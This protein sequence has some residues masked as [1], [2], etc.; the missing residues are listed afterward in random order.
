MI[1]KHVITIFY[2]VAFFKRYT[3]FPE[4]TK[5]H[6]QQH[7][8]KIQLCLTSNSS[9]DSSSLNLAK[10]TLI[11]NS[12]IDITFLFTATNE[13]WEIRNYNRKLFLRS[14][15]KKNKNAASILNC[16]FLKEI[17]TLAH[18]TKYLYVVN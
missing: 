10:N 13:L 2:T 17:F 4:H 8:K 1:L 16:Y 12:T 9:L 3:N 7:F 5:K 15:D 11:S 6:R 14:P 18:Q